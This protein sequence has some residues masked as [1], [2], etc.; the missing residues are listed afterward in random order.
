ML[1]LL[2]SDLDLSVLSE[3]KAER[4]SEFSTFFRNRKIFDCLS[5]LKDGIGGRLKKKK[6]KEE[7]ERV[8]RNSIP[9]YLELE[10][11]GVYASGAGVTRKRVKISA[12]SASSENSNRS[13]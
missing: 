12:A 6:K 5:W 10:S 4:N 11:G 3:R 7:E 13:F 9:G 2:V 1:L 8:K